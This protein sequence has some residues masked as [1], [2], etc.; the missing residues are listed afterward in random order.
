MRRAP[1]SSVAKTPGWP[2]VAMRSACWNPASSASRAISAQ[3][4]SMPRFSAAIDGW[5]IHSRSLCDRLVVTPLD[6][7]IDVVTPG[8]CHSLPC[9]PQRG[10]TADDATD[11]PTSRQIGHLLPLLYLVGRP[12]RTDSQ[13][14]VAGQRGPLRAPATRAPPHFARLTQGRRDLPRPSQFAA[15][16]SGTGRQKVSCV[17]IPRRPGSYDLR[18]GSNRVGMPR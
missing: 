11:K 18:C 2:L 4:S 3:P 6:L 16:G 13:R 8:G 17:A 14:A 7:A 10:A 9:G 1:A 5:W 15:R 12:D